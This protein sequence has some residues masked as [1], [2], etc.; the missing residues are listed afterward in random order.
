MIAICP[1]CHDAAHH[2]KLKI[3]DEALYQWKGIKRPPVPDSAHIYVE[4]ASELKLLTGTL[5]ISTTN[6][7]TVVF[8]LSNT[9][10]LKMRVLD[11]DI[12]QVSVCLK[13]QSGNEL[14]RVVENHVRVV[15]DKDIV[16]EFRA[17]HALITVPA[18]NDFAPR[19]L[20]DQVRVQDS[21]FAADERIIALDVEVLKPGLLRV[22]GCWPDGNVGVVI[23]EKA[24]SFCRRGMREPI[25]LVGAGEGTV[26]MY[27]GPITRA[28]FGFA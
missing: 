21:T 1:S 12:L 16:F 14:L 10:Q 13:D 18:T 15:R 20:I 5:C 19:W 11:G 8:Q 22:Q 26:L 7:Q 25:S 23:T 3:T 17:G 6:N 9:N 4:P 28:L 2:G 24:L 27:T